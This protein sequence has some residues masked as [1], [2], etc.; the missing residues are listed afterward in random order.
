MSLQIAF[1]SR[2]SQVSSFSYFG[3]DSQQ[4]AEARKRSLEKLHQRTEIASQTGGNSRSLE[5]RLYD[6]R[7]FCKIKTSEVAMYLPDEWRKG[8]FSQLDN[9]MDI[10]NWEEDDAPVA[11]ES[12]N[13]LLRM[14]TLIKPVRRPGL[15]STSSGHIIAAW[16]N[17][18]NRLTIE[19]LPSDRVRWVLSHVI[20]GIC[21]SAAGE[22][23]LIRLQAVLAPY[24]PNLWFH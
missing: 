11:R 1:S 16:T 8:F 13:T 10:E 9:L 4:I 6:A 7:A 21:E 24:S 12:F 15:G 18:T 14:L 22:V 5:E 17:Q 20:D 3:K 19:C 2:S 23:Q